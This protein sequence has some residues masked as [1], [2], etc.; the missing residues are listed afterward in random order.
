M[1]TGV[2][3]QRNDGLPHWLT[4]TVILTCL[5]L[6]VYVVLRFGLAGVPLATVI[7][8]LLGGYGGLDQLTKM[9]NQQREGG[10]DQP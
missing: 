3:E 4:V 10:G 5:G 7:A 2:G 8:G 6:F 1:E 9:R